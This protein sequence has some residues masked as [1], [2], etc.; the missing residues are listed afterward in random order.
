[1]RRRRKRLGFREI[2]LSAPDAR[3]E[4]VRRRVAGQVAVLH[5]ETE[6]DAVSWIEALSDF[7]ADGV[8]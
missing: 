5:P 1:M 4:A 2:P 8:R 6:A 7:D 3:A